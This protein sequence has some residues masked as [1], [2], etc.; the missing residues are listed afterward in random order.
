[1]SCLAVLAAGVLLSRKQAKR[2]RQL[3]SH[4]LEPRDYALLLFGLPGCAEDFWQDE[5]R[6]REFVEQSLG[7]GARP[8]V[9]QVVLGRDVPRLQ[10]LVKEY[11]RLQQGQEEE[12]DGTSPLLPSPLT[13][14]E[15]QQ[16]LTVPEKLLAELRCHPCCVVVLRYPEDRKQIL[17]R[18]DTV[19]E[20]GLWVMRGAC[21]VA[22][23]CG[24][25]VEDTTFSSQSSLPQIEG[26][27]PVRICGA[28]DPSDLLWENFGAS[29]AD[30]FFARLRTHAILVLLLAG[31]VLVNW[32]VETLTGG[33]LGGAWWVMLLRCLTL[34][35][36]NLLASYLNKRSNVQELHLTRTDQ[37]DSLMVKLSL[38]MAVN[39]TFLLL[40]VYWN[41][42]ESWY[43][44]GGLLSTIHM[45]MPLDTV[46]IS[47]FTYYGL[48]SSL[49]KCLEA[50]LSP[51]DLTAPSLTQAQLNK[52][53]EPG[54]MN[55]AR[56]F[57]HLIKSFLMCLFFLPFWPLGSAWMVLSL[58]LK[59]LAYKKQ[60][61]RDS[62][63]PYRQSHVI[64][65]SAGNFVYVGAL[66]YAFSAWCFLSPSLRGAGASALAWPTPLLAL[67]G[68]HL[69]LAPRWLTDCYGA[70]LAPLARLA[71]GLAT[72]TFW[73]ERLEESDGM[74]EGNYDYYNVQGC[75]TRSQK[76]HTSSPAY[77]Q[78]TRAMQAQR[79]P[80]P[81]DPDSG[82]LPTP[83]DTA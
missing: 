33:R 73:R 46:I 5:A 6:V 31:G 22:A 72:A 48:G 63:R 58:V 27:Y 29:S 56:P 71:K 16:V 41:A 60:L 43:Y 3:D 11:Q 24:L 19:W 68:A 9:V 12:A 51:L 65:F 62:K 4:E 21:E 25:R 35:A 79:Q 61:L 55:V 26:R 76:Y 39:Y 23:A 10:A 38:F 45:L 47:L 53:C 81:W 1:V 36:V 75:W 69:L 14:E 18:W 50:K 66:V 77:Q 34:V 67:A 59:T 2:M 7:A 70:W 49:G 28:M 37:D 80:T 13:L 78:L 57:A 8:E 83:E 52:R 32:T 15:L 54:E 74:G 30:C 40:A 82:N 44:V 64:A 17:S 20:R 42:G